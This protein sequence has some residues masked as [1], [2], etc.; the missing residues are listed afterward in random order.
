MSVTFVNFKHKVHTGDTYQR[1]KKYRTS[2]ASNIS[3]FI[4]NRPNGNTAIARILV[5]P[6]GNVWSEDSPETEIQPGSTTL[7]VPN[8]WAKYITVAYKSKSPS[9]PTTLD[10]WVQLTRP[11][12]KYCF[13]VGND[14]R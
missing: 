3:F 7:L 14:W 8:F 10:I 11:P 13:G 5:S 4:S 1:L 6:D 2:F 12:A 9:Q